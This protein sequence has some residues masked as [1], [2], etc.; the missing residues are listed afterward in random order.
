M[1]LVARQQVKIWKTG[2][3]SHH[4]IAEISLN[5]TLKHNQPTNLNIFRE[6]RLKQFIDKLAKKITS[7]D[8]IT[9]R[10]PSFF[11][12]CP[13]IGVGSRKNSY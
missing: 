8:S 3:L 10:R 4:Y 2:Q 9:F 5:V 11:V 7:D 13:E 12:K 6:G 1:A